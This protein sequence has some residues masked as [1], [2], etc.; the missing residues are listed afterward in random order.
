MFTGLIQDVGTVE[1]IQ[2]RGREARMTIRTALSMDEWQ[3]GDSVA[4][5][6]TCLTATTMTGGCFTA[7]LS[8]ETLK[9]TSFA[10]S[11]I[12]DRVNLELALRLGD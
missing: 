11:R 4:V 1:A 8:E 10:E 9:R 2:R 12:G 3:V 6:G 7:D 5:H